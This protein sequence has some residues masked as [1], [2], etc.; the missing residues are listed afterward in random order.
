MYSL[1]CIV[2]RSPSRSQELAESFATDVR[3][4]QD[5]TLNLSID[6]A[7]Q[8]KVGIA[9]FASWLEIPDKSPSRAI[10]LVQL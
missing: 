8:A 1:F 9:A 2:P 7:N 4:E 6:I 3:E 5:D 10:V